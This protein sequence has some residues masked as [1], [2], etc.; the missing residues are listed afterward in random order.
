M[1]EFSVKK[2]LSFSTILAKASKFILLMRAWTSLLEAIIVGTS[3][4]KSSKHLFGCKNVFLV[5]I[6]LT[7]IQNFFFFGNPRIC[8]TL[9]HS[10][11]RMLYIF[12]NQT[13]EPCCINDD[14]SLLSSKQ[15]LSRTYIHVLKCRTSCYIAAPKSQIGPRPFL[16]R[17]RHRSKRQLQIACNCSFSRL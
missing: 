10:C 14:S 2:P 5:W 3:F 6:N 13:K 11:L 9:L 7:F 16:V 12:D 17:T 15:M 8:E 1:C 4:L